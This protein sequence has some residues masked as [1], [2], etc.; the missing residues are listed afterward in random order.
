[1]RKLLLAFA[2]V[3]AAFGALFV[4]PTR[5]AHT[6]YSQ[7]PVRIDRVSG[8]AEVLT[9]AGWR[10]LRAQ[11]PVAPVVVAPSTRPADESWRAFYTPPVRAA[12]YPGE[13][14]PS[15]NYTLNVGMLRFMPITAAQIARMPKELT[16]EQVAM[17]PADWD[18]ETEP[19]R[20]V[21]Q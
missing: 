19:L 10:P 12:Q 17:V 15:R 5:Y 7:H 3:V 9:P 4:W 14:A 18:P 2:L 6:T 11:Q 13:P 8:D 20:L 1:M 21:S 16:P